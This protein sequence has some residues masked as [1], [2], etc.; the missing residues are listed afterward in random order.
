MWNL[1]PLP[2]ACPPW[3][4]LGKRL[5]SSVRKAVYEY[6][7]FE[8]ESRIAIALSGGKDSLSLLFLLHAISGRGFPKWEIHAVHVNGA[9]SCGAGIE[10]NF[11][12]RICKEL[13]IPFH[14]C[15]SLQKREGLECYSCSRE[16]RRLIF[17]KAKSIGANTIA[18]GHH[19]DDNAQTILMNLFHKGEFVGNLP[20]LEMVDFGIT[21]VR[22]LILIA[23]ADIR[24]FAK[25][26]GFARITCQCPVGQNSVRKKID[27]LLKELE[28]LFPHVRSNVS[29]AGLVYGS[30]KAVRIPKTSDYKRNEYASTNSE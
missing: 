7:L 19:R 27:C 26:Y 5:E 16:R 17:E 13:N 15:T 12:R 22:P 9:F 14:V 28:E 25:E 8:G 24:Q 29:K 20:K 2:I 18:F 10:E 6:K 4:K 30:N 23:E 1:S 11:L 3:K 21:I